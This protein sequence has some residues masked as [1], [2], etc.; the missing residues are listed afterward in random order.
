MKGN[1]IAKKINTVQFK[2]TPEI[3]NLVPTRTTKSHTS[4]RSLVSDSIPTHSHTPQKICTTP[5]TD[6]TNYSV[7]STTN[8][9]ST[10]ISKTLSGFYSRNPR[11]PA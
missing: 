2:K 7:D 3:Q 1:N 6:Y 8:P 11:P 10:N 4:V 9:R 5:S